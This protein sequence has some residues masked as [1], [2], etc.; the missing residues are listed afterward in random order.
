MKMRIVHVFV[1]LVL[2]LSACA[3]QGN[4]TPILPDVPTETPA[5]LPTPT[6]V[7]R[8]LNICLGE[9]PTTLYP[10]GGLSSAARSVLSAIYDGP[11]DMVGYGYEAVILEKVP[12]IADGDAQ[13]NPVA[14]SA[15]DLVV[16]STGA[17]VSLA[18]GVRV[19][20]GGC[21]SDACAITYDGSSSIQMDQMVVTFTM[22][23]G[24][25][26]SDGEPLT[27]GDSVYSFNLASNDDTPVSKYLV[28]RTETYEAADDI[29]VQWWGVPGF[30]DTDYQTNFWMPLPQHVWDEF[31]AADL[32]QVDVSTRAPLG[33]G[34]YV[35]DE[36]TPGEGIHLVKNL[37]Y[38]RADSDLPKFDELNFHFV[39]D[40]NAALT[41]LV[42][43]TCD[44]L[45]PSVR[46]D[47]QVALLQQ[48]QADGQAQ[49]LTAPTNTM[50]WLGIGIAHVSYDDGYNST[51]FNPDRPDYFGDVRTRQ[52]IA[53]CLDRQKVVDTVLF[54]LSQVPDSYLPPDHPLHNG[55]IQTYAFDP[56]R[57]NQ[58]L[59]QVGWLDHDK[60]PS[61]PRQAFGVTGIPV[62]TP[63]VLNYYTTSAT[64]RRQ[65]V[66]IFTQSL[67]DCG[68]GLNP[69]YYT[70]ADFY[71]Q[72]PAGPL[73]GR[74]FDLA[75]YAIGVDTIEPQ[76]GWFT[77]AQIPTA[78]NNWIGTNISGYSN[79]EFDSACE[80]ALQSLPDDPEYALHQQA[81]AT[82]ASE[83]P[84]IP[85]YLRLKV[86][87]TRNDFCGFT[88]DP[89]SSYALADLESFDYG[90]SCGP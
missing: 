54:G 41:A 11:I 88:L 73:F 35:M 27:A 15:G 16:D 48:M 34:A 72:G 20:P 55:N 7:S 80:Q 1:L 4:E 82:F 85:L 81:Q 9:E 59:E 70:A 44:V 75:E 18:T 17:V 22:L 30:I 14:V 86:A 42:D 24:L 45:D 32:L 38:F 87:A 74:Q 61:T 77:T 60:D 12:D 69:V 89:T 29:T 31:S 57:G 13:V 26:W 2:T 76:C 58:I 25:M 63:L 68:I 56:A 10:Y 23:E 8:S 64:Q 47:G 28:D 52:A 3:P 36:W 37:N 90:T 66:E 65:V 46:L 84:S 51:G 21:R 39:T 49:L 79:P 71:A 53:A 78:D 83:L 33:W 67:A 19:R 5:P 40:A 50:E 62:G 6:P 43:G